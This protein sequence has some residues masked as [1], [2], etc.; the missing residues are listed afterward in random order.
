VIWRIEQIK[1]PASLSG[2]STNY[3]TPFTA[4]N[5]S[6]VQLPIQCSDRSLFKGTNSRKYYGVPSADMSAQS[7]I[8][9][10]AK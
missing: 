7:K 10:P 9:S 4:T 2:T 6:M 8:I 3:G 1:F 5:S